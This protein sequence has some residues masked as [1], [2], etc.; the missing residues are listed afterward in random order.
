[1]K[2]SAPKKNRFKKMKNNPKSGKKR[3]GNRFWTLTDRLVMIEK[4]HAH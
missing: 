2:N 3:K 1:M 4:N